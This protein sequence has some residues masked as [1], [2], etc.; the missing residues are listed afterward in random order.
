MARITDRDALKRKGRL[1]GQARR[2]LRGAGERREETR[3]RLGGFAFFEVVSLCEIRIAPVRAG[4][5]RS[6]G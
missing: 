3:G 1:A 5:D 6:S 2:P 4:C